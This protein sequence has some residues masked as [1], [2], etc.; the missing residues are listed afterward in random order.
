MRL[1]AALILVLIVSFAAFGQTYTINT[2]VGG[3]LPQNIAASSASLG[4]I[5][6]VAAD[7]SGNV[8]LA[9]S[10]YAVVLKMDTGGKLTLVAGTGAPGFS[11]DGHLAINAQLSSPSALAV[12]TSGNVYIADGVRI[13][14]VSGGTI[15]TIAGGGTNTGENVTATSAQLWAVTHLAVDKS[16]IVYFYD[17]GN[18]TSAALPRIRMVSSGTIS[19]VA[20]GGTAAIGTGPATSADLSSLCGMALDGNGNLYLT[21]AWTYSLVREIS[22]GTITTIAGIESTT[23]SGYSGDK[24]PAASAALY[25]PMGITVDKAGDIYFI[26]FWNGVVRKIDTTETI[27]TIAGNGTIGDTGDGGP[28]I[29][30]GL[31]FHYQRISPRITV[32]PG[33]ELVY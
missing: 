11:G 17:Y 19:T 8:Y 27:T 21:I 26:D 1:F 14:E 25:W 2:L 23:G 24:G 32:D 18:G 28:A 9:L 4:T 33:W 3:A 6:D 31:L 20:G 12:D 29:D 16:G 13:R 10:D 22:A 7:L 30:A 5:S 15:A